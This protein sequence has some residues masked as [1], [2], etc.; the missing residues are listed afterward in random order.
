M[1]LRP[2]KCPKCACPLTYI[3][4][5]GTCRPFDNS[6][7]VFISPLQ[8]ERRPVWSQSEVSSTTS[9]T[10]FW[11]V[12]AG[13]APPWQ[14]G[15]VKR[16]AGTGVFLQA[17]EGSATSVGWVKK[18]RSQPFFFPLG[19]KGAQD[20]SL[21]FGA[22]FFCIPHQLAEQPCQGEKKVLVFL[23]TS[24]HGMM[25]ERRHISGHHIMWLL[26]A[27][28]M[29]KVV[30][31]GLPLLFLCCEVLS[32]ITRAGCSPTNAADHRGNN[33]CCNPLQRP[34]GPGP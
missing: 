1:K 11:C 26:K 3:P 2:P 10:P 22:E 16:G 7:V 5:P 18:L 25:G 15:G 23:D 27:Q 14:R 12:G 20:D 6:F 28:E 30:L 31:L 29:K 4:Y 33:G 32:L 34:A 19:N 9:R 24:F 8:G 17:S 13:F 21:V